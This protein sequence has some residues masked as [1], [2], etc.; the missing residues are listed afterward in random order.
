MIGRSRIL[1][2]LLISSALAGC[3]TQS[4]VQVQQPFEPAKHRTVRIEPCQDRT[5]FEGTRDLAGEATRV[6][7]E[8]VA[9]TKLFEVAADAP[10]V[11]T[12]DIERFAE[13]SAFKRWLMPGWGATQAAVAVIV[14]EKPGDKMLATLRSQSSVSAGGLYTIGADQYILS[15][16]F[17]EIVKQLEAWAHQ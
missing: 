15:V 11:L 2:A 7:T 13:G 5:G 10:L 9:A 3:A 6:L 14:W 4:A 12:C 16:A 17:D 8:K 1:S